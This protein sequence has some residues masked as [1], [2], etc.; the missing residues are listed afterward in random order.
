MKIGII[1]SNLY[2]DE[3]KIKK[4]IFN[5]KTKMNADPS[6]ITIISRGGKDG[7][8]YYIKKF[9]LEFGYQY[10]ELNPCHETKNLYSIMPDSWYGKNYSSF[11]YIMRDKIFSSY[12]DKVVCFKKPADKG[13]TVSNCISFL[14]KANKKVIVID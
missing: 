14:E 9:A 11:N 10:R 3:M 4:F 6:T 8:E 1:G 12:V 5:L 2:E 13:M 7:A